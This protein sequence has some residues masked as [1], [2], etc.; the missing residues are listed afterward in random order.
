MTENNQND[1]KPK[2]SFWNDRNRALLVTAIAFL[3]YL[4]LTNQITETATLITN[5][6]N[7]S[8]NIGNAMI[9]TIGM[10]WVSAVFLTVYEINDPERRFKNKLMLLLIA[11][12][13]LANVFGDDIITGT[14]SE[15]ILTL[16]FAIGS[17]SVCAYIIASIGLYLNERINR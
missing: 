13:I 4:M 10:T 5:I 6:I 2:G 11:A 9:V 17:M 15:Q 1:Q 3:P 8:E 7:V 12:V 16:L 14:G